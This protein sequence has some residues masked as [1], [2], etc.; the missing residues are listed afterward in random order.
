MKV[1]KNRATF[2]RCR[3]CGHLIRVG[4]SMVTQRR[5]YD[6]SS[7]PARIRTDRYHDGC[8]PVLEPGEEI[9]MITK[10]G[11]DWTESWVNGRIA[12]VRLEPIR[13]HEVVDTVNGW[14]LD[15]MLR[16]FACYATEERR[17]RWRTTVQGGG[18]GSRRYERHETE[19][20]ARQHL[21][22]WYYRRYR[23]VETIVKEDTP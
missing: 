21:I 18:G 4:E 20:E 14:M 10:P 17:D 12:A 13:P 15:R 3:G 11:F 1:S 22:N 7:S 23:R 8:E 5:W 19:D 2:R 9:E 16:M 6:T